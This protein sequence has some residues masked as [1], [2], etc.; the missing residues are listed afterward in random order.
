VDKQ[1][2]ALLMFGCYKTLSDKD[3]TIAYE[4]SKT[5]LRSVAMVESAHLSAT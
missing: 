2:V 1:A 5:D 3:V 4:A